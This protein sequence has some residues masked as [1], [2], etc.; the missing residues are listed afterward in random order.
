MATDIRYLLNK[1]DGLGDDNENG[2][3][4][5]TDFVKLVTA[6]QE[7]QE[8][9]KGVVKEIKFD[10]NSY[11]PD[12]G[13]V[14]FNTIDTDGRLV[15]VNTDLQ[16]I[17][18]GKGE[19]CIITVTVTDQ[20]LNKND[21]SE[22]TPYTLPGVL[23]FYLKNSNTT[24]YNDYNEGTKRIHTI[25]GVYDSES[26]NK[27]YSFDANTTDLLTLGQN[28]IYV[29][30]T[31][32]DKIIKNTHIVVLISEVQ[33]VVSDFNS[34]YTDIENDK[35]NVTVYG[36]EG[37]SSYKLCL[38]IDNTEE[39][40]YDIFKDIKYNILE[41]LDNQSKIGLNY[42][43]HNIK[44]HV[45]YTPAENII[46][47][48]ETREYNYICGY[49]DENESPVVVTNILEGS[50]YKVYSKLDVNYYAYMPFTVNNGQLKL[51]LI[52]KTNKVLKTHI[53]DI[54]FTRN[55]CEGS[56][57][58][59]LFPDNYTEFIGETTLR[60]S[61]MSNEIVKCLYDVKI[62]II[63]NTDIK[64]AET[65]EYLAYF[66]SAGRTNAESLETL[67]KWECKTDVKTSNLPTI[68][69]DESISFNESGSGWLAD[70]NGNVAMHLRKFNHFTL[71][72]K[73]FETS[74]IA[75]KDKD[76]TKYT[77][78]G[79]TL[80]FE[81]A[82]RNCLDPNTPVI[83]CMDYDEDKKP[84]KGFV[85][86]ANSILLKGSDI[87]L[88]TTFKEDTRIKLD[89]VIEGNTTPYHIKT[90][91][92]SGKKNDPVKEY[93]TIFDE[94][95]VKI[96]VD[97]V[98]AG[99][100]QATESTDFLQDVATYIRFGSD[101]CD[102]DVYNIR[103]YEKA[104]SITDILKNYSYDT[105]NLEEKISIFARN[106]IYSDT[107]TT[108]QMII[109]GNTVDVTY[110]N[111]PN[112]SIEKLKTAL[113][114]LPFIFVTLD[115]INNGKNGYSVDEL[116]KDKDNWHLLSK[117]TFENTGI[118]MEDY[119]K[120]NYSSIPLVSFE[121]NTGVL[122]NQ[123]TSSMTYP[124]PWRN[125]DLK[126]GD[127]DF[128][129]I[130]DEDAYKDTFL[131]YIP[132][133]TGNPTDA[134]TSKWYQYEYTKNLND[135]TLD[136]YKKLPIKK[137]TLKK[138]YASSEMCNN[139]ICSEMFTDMAI[140]IAN[141]YNSVLSPT[142]REEYDKYGITNL[143]LTLKAQPC[144]MFRYY[145]DSTK[146]GT[147][148]KGIEALGMMNLIPNK[149]EVGYLGFTKNVWENLEDIAK[150]LEYINDDET[151][152]DL[153][154]DEINAINN[155]LKYRQQSWELKD[156]KDDTFWVEYITPLVNKDGFIDKKYSGEENIVVDNLP[157]KFATPIDD[158]YEARTPKDSSIFSDTDFGYVPDEPETGFKYDD[159]VRLHNETK[160]IIDFHNW[161]VATNRGGTTCDLTI[162]EINKMSNEDKLEIAKFKLS[163]EQLTETDSWNLKNGIYTYQYDTKAFRLEKFRNESPYRLLLDQW[164]LYYIWREQFWMF[165]SGL[166]N[167]QVYT[168]G[169]KEDKEKVY[170]VLQWG[171]MVR[172]ADTALGINNV[173]QQYFLPHIEDIDTY[174][175]GETIGG[176]AN[177]TFNYGAGKNIYNRADL[178]GSEAVLNGQFA[179]IWVNLRD[180]Y[181][182]EIAEMYR[183]LIKSCDKFGAD[184]TINV[185]RNHQENWCEALY[186][187]GMRQYIG[188]D[189]FTAH[190]HSAL[191]D[192]KNS[193]ASWL[194]N[195][196]VYRQSKYKCVRNIGGSTGWRINV[197]KSPDF[198]EGY[199]VSKYDEK[200]LTIQTYLP[201]YFSCGVTEDDETKCNPIRIIPDDNGNCIKDISV[202]TNGFDFGETG[203]DVSFMFGTNFI[204]DMGDI[205]RYCKVNYFQSLE[206]FKKLRHLRLGHEYDI[207]EKYYNEFAYKYLTED[208]F[209]TISQELREKYEKYTV[210]DGFYLDTNG[211]KI[212]IG[213]DFEKERIF[214]N[215]TLLNLP[216]GSLKE[217]ILLDVTNHTAL[218]TLNNLNV[219]TQLETLY[220]RGTN[221]SSV[222]LPETS[223]LKT[224][225]LGSNLTSLNLS[226]LTG[227]EKLVIADAEDNSKTTGFNLDK[228]TSITIK[229]P[230]PYLKGKTS[231]DLIKSVIDNNTFKSCVLEGID[232]ID[233]D[234]SFLI[235][236]S[237][238]CSKENIKGTIK[239]KSLNMADKLYFKTLYGDI[240]NND[241]RYGLYI[242][243]PKVDIGEITLTQNIYIN[244]A[245][246]HQL[247]FTPQYTIGNNVIS[248]EWDVTQDITYE[249]NSEIVEG[250]EP[251][252]KLDKKTGILTVNKLGH[253]DNAPIIKVNVNVKCLVDGK[254][255]IRPSNSDM[256][257][258]LYY[259]S[260]QVGDIVYN[261]GSY[262]YAKDYN[263]ED[264]SKEPIG[265]C[266]YVRP[267]HYDANTDTYVRELRLMYA[268]NDISICDDYNRYY[269]WGPHTELK[270]DINHPV[271]GDTV[272][273][274]LPLSYNINQFIIPTKNNIIRVAGTISK[275]LDDFINRLYDTKTNKWLNK[276]INWNVETQ[277]PEASIGIIVNEDKSCNN[278]P[279][280]KYFTQCII[281]HRNNVLE[282]LR[283]AEYLTGIDSV[284]NWISPE[285]RLKQLLEHDQT[286]TEH[287]A[288]KNLLDSLTGLRVECYYYPFASLCYAYE[289]IIPEGLSLADDFKAKNWW[290]PAPGEML[291]CMLLNIL[292]IDDKNGDNYLPEINK[293]KPTLDVL[294]TAKKYDDLVFLGSY[295]SSDMYYYGTS[296]ECD[297]YKQ[298]ALTGEEYDCSNKAFYVGNKVNATNNFGALFG[299][300][301]HSSRK[302]RP[303]CEF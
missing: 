298:K 104:I 107:P 148:G 105:P 61:I 122:R 225:Y 35:F 38:Y 184:N 199:D 299:K 16:R 258:H 77:G 188:G 100:V 165:D 290:L 286:H 11:F 220:A 294:R 21:N 78:K 46:A 174:N 73:P 167:L 204:T 223:S 217:L 183:S 84:K 267:K 179:S 235:K 65:P 218:S 233:V 71:N 9:V 22:H 33:L 147:A 207:D 180:V 259:R 262:G 142:M 272:L 154:S 80:S 49:Q 90:V 284:R 143:R 145:Q 13:V 127:T 144:F 215:E 178:T 224:I 101:F 251:S 229:N 266:F 5:A 172:D 166:K 159:I 19:S 250:Y 12:N 133:Y 88:T 30:Y 17:Y 200:K 141:K 82:T 213:T 102:L 195:S 219:C 285:D 162:D 187:F 41:I 201:M 210:K 97:G 56:Y 277:L 268:L 155:T 47:Q 139:A 212:V 157:L 243:Y 123:G 151:E 242:T 85:V 190:I 134:R 54:I 132:K 176:K 42:G 45:K 24:L 160:D 8:A 256:T 67:K 198:Y 109:N 150:E 115:E 23:N 240:D 120:E 197:Y 48:T 137:I 57:S 205:A 129:G 40:E 253:E 10:G 232:W 131:Y 152:D 255:E 116:P 269:H 248:Y 279:V 194:Y 44:I 64:L 86:K 193:R 27:S 29:T 136:S 50:S 300:K 53:E 106:N 153:T 173:G 303:I 138:D 163:D 89:I 301:T 161:L 282:K 113:P 31:S 158:K 244:S 169:P 59:V 68:T 283:E 231:Y 92:G 236:L 264:K 62:N 112:I 214:T 128:R 260:A 60:L 121:L 265:I 196:F 189:A 228:C 227:L 83:D 91:T 276:Q 36:S 293:L 182:N 175:I 18:K 28:I 270:E 287:T 168:M 156:N 58:F 3:L 302:L 239:L 171:C 238:R 4:F 164:I 81:F 94:C 135:S 74:P 222:A 32:D 34:I 6:V 246:E 281:N 96:F 296:S 261:D 125:W 76:I 185:F 208:N 230:S 95:Y 177:I 63:E 118:K 289:P 39:I 20:I 203:D 52:N 103:I 257:V 295:G 66:T 245:G 99:I 280:G 192:K 51:E 130:M 278:L 181:S 226:N 146:E 291:H 234:S 263:S 93:D 249:G 124:W 288:L 26:E 111:L 2:M 191:G 237:K 273:D 186:N 75:L 209:N 140:S 37:V 69:F 211:S 117:T 274:A 25:D 252:Y 70:N 79:L 271:E 87:E 108:K 43:V 14:T 15:E 114:N 7:N 202:G 297:V 119:S 1:R 126:T 110:D 72:Y 292:A 221:L 275:N 247:M 216:C 98:Y 149:N 55:Y 241:P 254:E 206:H 170:D